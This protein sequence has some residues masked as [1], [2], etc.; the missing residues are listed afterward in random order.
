MKDIENDLRK[1]VGERVTA[2]DYERWFYSSDILVVPNLVKKLFQTMPAAVV[3]ANTT[4]EVSAVLAYCN[5]NE[6]PVVPRGAG[7]SGLFGAV[8]KKGG[9]VLDLMNLSQVIGVDED[10]ETVTT[11]AGI[12]CW[13]LDRRLRKANLTLRSYPSSARSATIG[14]WIMGSGLGIGSIGY[15]P[16]I[17]H[18]VS[19]EIVL[20]DGTVKEYSRGKE[21]DLFAESEGTL[22]VMTRVCLKV[23]KLPRHSAYYLIRFEEM[24]ELFE[25]VHALAKM[26]PQPYNIEFLDHEYLTLLRA[27]GYESADAG[28]RGGTALVTYEGEKEETEASKSVIDKLTGSYHSEEIE[29]AQHEWEQRFNILRIR[30]AAPTVFL[31]SV[32]IPLTSL[33]QFYTGMNKLDKR[34]LG[35]L[36]YIISDSEC[37][38][39]PIVVTDEN[40]QAEYL[41]S[42]HTPRELSNL[43]LNLGGKPGGGVGVWNAPY[44]EH[45]LSGK[46]F[47]EIKKC[48]EQLDSKGILNPGMWLHSPLFLNSAVY[49]SAMTAVSIA[50]KLIPSTVKKDVSPGFKEEIATCVQCGYCMNYCPT[51]QIWVSSTPRGRIL[52]AKDLLENKTLRY[53]KIDDE[54]LKSV[55]ECTMCGRCKVNCS[56]DIKSPELWRDLRSDIVKKGFELENLK[57]LTSSINQT[58]NIPGKS[59][60]LR[61]QWTRRLKLPY[62]IGSKT[63]AEVIYFVGCLTSFY[64]MVQDI[65]GSFAHILDRAGTDFTILGGEEWCCGYPLMVAG[66]TEDAASSMRH[67]IERIEG[68]GAKTVVMTCPGCYR[69]WKDE[70]HEI[71]GHK[72]R[73]DVFHSTEYITGLMEQHKIEL[74]GFDAN[75][76]YHDPCDLGR[77]SGIFDE[78]RYIMNRIPGL[79]LVELDD[80][81]EYC[82]CC[83]SGGDLLAS[84]Q[85]LSLSIAGR[86]IEEILNTGTDRVVTACPA[87][88]RSLN[89]VKT[90]NKVKVDIMDISQLVWK[91]MGD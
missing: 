61:A 91:A 84:S 36:G 80:N 53:E 58:H 35:L 69:M 27:A 3:K 76:T 88:I 85:S 83:G 34:P 19:A 33:N 41:M 17:E 78:P 55:F 6:I 12:T 40:K 51:R 9:V 10:R 8:P 20:A 87:C 82:S 48:K 24:R 71:T 26:T 46:K 39:M 73:F 29:G 4:E 47:E 43:A 65:A 57:N 18:L 50:D 30:R 79:G 60:D 25:Y 23:R 14:G 7:S 52:K 75:I 38:A 67:N 62:D 11:E 31:T 54:Y 21:L 1:I 59:N 28:P 90:A 81:R 42:L 37:M 56:V 13:E 74:K 5:R 44:K 68:M 86:K 2:G 63:N 22:G 49:Q 66:H 16:I 77:N 72:P 89:M 15:G 64:P 45:V 32:H 70:Y